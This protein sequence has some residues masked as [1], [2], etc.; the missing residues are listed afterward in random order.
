[1]AKRCWIFF[2][3]DAKTTSLRKGIARR[4]AEIEPVLVVER[5]VSVARSATGWSLSQRV[6]GIEYRPLHLPERV[7]VVGRAIRKCN[8]RRIRR[9]LDRLCPP[10]DR[11]VCYDSPAQHDFVGKLNEHCRIYLATDDWTVTLGGDPIPGELEAERKLLAQV[12]RVI[13][14]G[15]TLPDVL[16]PRVPEG[17]APRFDVLDSAFDE[18]LFDPAKTYSDPDLLR[19]VPRPR[20]VIPGHVSERID[21]EGVAAC[22]RLRPDVHWVFVGPADEGMAERVASIGAHLRPKAPV[23]QIPGWLQHSDF[24]AVPY[25]LNAFTKASSPLKAMEALAL[26]V[27]TLS[28]RVP[29]LEQFGQTIQWVR[30]GDGDSYR[31]AVEGLLAEGRSP[32]AKARRQ[33]AVASFTL[34]ARVEQ[35]LKLCS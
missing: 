32:A 1:M 30:E 24:C 27:P 6:S 35:F 23:E 10:G 5:G 14:I 29:V 11:I 25:R 31:S 18:R 34:E 2:A 13:C 19:D 9:E 4:V 7:P 21:W 17:C 33:A 12:D 26:G 3:I 8:I 15:Q 28:T 16:R 22:R 20:G